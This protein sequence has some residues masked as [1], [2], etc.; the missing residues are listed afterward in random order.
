MLDGSIGGHG[1]VTKLFYYFPGSNTAFRVGCYICELLSFSDHCEPLDVLTSIRNVR[2][3]TAPEAAGVI[4]TDFEKHFI[5]AEVVA[6]ADFK[7]VARDKNGIADCKAAGKWRQEGKTYGVQD[8]DI[9]H[10][11]A[12]SVPLALSVE[13]F[14]T[15]LG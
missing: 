1:Y 12:S 8:G 15:S 14:L 13:R 3:P 2:I 4:H 11:Q 10:F 6:W 5:K 7:E 9:I